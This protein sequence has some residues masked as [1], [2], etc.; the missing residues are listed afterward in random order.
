M[1]VRFSQCVS[2]TGAIFLLSLVAGLVGIANA[3]EI[4][5]GGTGNALGSMRLM[6]DAFSAKFPDIKVTV[7]GSIGTSGAI[8]GVPKGD[9]GIGVS[10]RPLTAEESATGLI[11]TE[12]ARTLTVFAVSNKSKV[13]AITSSQLAEIYNGSLGKWPDGTTIRPVLRQPGDDNTKQVRSISPDVEKALSTAENREGLAHAFIDQEAADKIESI[14]GAIGISTLALIKSEGRSLRP[15]IFNG[16]EPTVKNGANGAYPLIKHFYFLT[17]KD[18]VP[19]VQKF[20]AFANSPA[21]QDLLTKNGHW[22][23]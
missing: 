15:L 8:K 14:P 17:L 18:P 1:G 4:K 22:H 10:S 23:P 2:R 16:V 9:I 21:G 6:G 19:A 7:L 11:A 5:I 12:Y 20:M 13:T 3:E